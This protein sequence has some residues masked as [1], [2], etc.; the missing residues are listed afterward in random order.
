MDESEFAPLIDLS[1]MSLADLVADSD[2]DSPLGRA[3]RRVLE[4]LEDEDGALTAFQS[5]I[6]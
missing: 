3:A 2:E 1:G 6:S 4:Q 5:F